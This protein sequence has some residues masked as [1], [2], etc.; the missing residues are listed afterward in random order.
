[1]KQRLTILVALCCGLV[2]GCEE[3]EYTISMKADGD[4]VTRRIACSENVGEETRDRLKQLYDR[5]IDRNTFKGRF[6]EK[7]PADVGGFGRYVHLAGPM[8]QVS[9]YIERFG[10]KDAQALDMEKAFAAAD[11]LVNLF[12][13][14]LEFE[15]GDDPNFENLRT[16]CNKDLREDAKNLAVYLWVGSRVPGTEDSEAAARMLLYLYERDYF[17]LDDLAAFAA[18]TDM[19]KTALQFLRKFITGKLGYSSEKQTPERMSFLRD[20]N[21]VE[22][23]VQ[24]FVSS[25]KV[26]DRL[27]RQAREQSGDPN[28][29]I[30]P[31]DMPEHV[32][33]SYGIELETFFIDFELFS[34]PDKVNVILTCPHKPHETNGQWDQAKGQVSWSSKIEDKDLPFL[35]YASIGEPNDAFQK[36]HFGKVILRGEQLVQYAFWRRGLSDRRQAQWDEFLASLEGGA[37]VRERIESFRFK[38]SADVSEGEQEAAERLSEAARDLIMEGLNASDKKPDEP[39]PEGSAGVQ[40]QAYTVEPIGRVTRKND[41]TF[42]E[43]DEKYKAGLKGL[44]RH[45]YVT[46]VYWFD[47]NDTPQKRSILEV[48]PRADVNNPLTGVFATHSPFRPNLIAISRCDIVSVKDNVIEI[49]S[50]DAFDGSPV[51]DLKGDFFR[52]YKPNLK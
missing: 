13:E 24:R 4:T 9:I 49:E 2:G 33:E 19:E 34:R 1:M 37:E 32:F 21:S 36:Q 16:F 39:G 28:L 8:G 17:D 38:D 3:E 15:L 48:H 25:P 10:G 6:G 30:E 51:L 44:E 7:L 43:I 11:Q 45:S 31:N 5:Q 50:I 12:V 47:R 14:W 35:C 40:R 52:F 46:V 26:Y 18:S 23:S 22:S 20:T 27:L 42:I 41:R 29:V